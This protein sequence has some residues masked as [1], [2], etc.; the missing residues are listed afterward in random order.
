MEV[1]RI[2]RWTVASYSC[3]HVLNDACASAWFSY[4]LIYLTSAR[5]LSGVEAGAVLFSGQ[6]ADALATPVAGLLSDRGGSLAA[7]GFGRRKFWNFVGVCLV[8]VAFYFLFGSCVLCDADAGA[9][10]AAA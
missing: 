8:V 2:S 6:L 7:L 4:L 1:P 10:S 3:G 9:S 5:G